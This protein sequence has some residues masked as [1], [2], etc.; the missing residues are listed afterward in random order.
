MASTEV[1]VAFAIATALFAYFPGPALLYT[2]AQTLSRGR[3]AGLMAALGIHVGCYA[4]VIAATLGLSAVFRYVPEAYTALKIAG[5]AYL[6]WL[7][8][9]MLRGGIAGD[10]PKVTPKSARRAFAESIVV[11]LLNPKVAI[12]FIAFLPQFVDPAGSLPVWLQSLILGVIINLAFSSADVVTV[13][14]AS[15]VVGRLR[16]SGTMERAARWIGGSLLIGLGVKLG[17]D[18]T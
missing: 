16:K 17:F 7:G 8:I 2:A 4:H 18:K 15:A 11:E 9:Q 1:L 3:R 10:A 13:F 5:A 6:V 14:A 12:F